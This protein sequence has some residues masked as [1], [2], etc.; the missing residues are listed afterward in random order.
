M[1]KKV[2]KFLF[3]ILLTVNFQ[4]VFANDQTYTLIKGYAG[5]SNRIRKY[6]QFVY[7]YCQK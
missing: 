4:E 3:F 2:L 6:D 7:T 5:S 1:F